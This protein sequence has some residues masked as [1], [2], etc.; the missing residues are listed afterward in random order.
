M[1]QDKNKRYIG[2]IVC[3]NGHYYFKS[4]K[5]SVF[6]IIQDS[7]AKALCENES[8]CVFELLKTKNP[9]DKFGKV[10]KILDN[11]RN[12][13][14]IIQAVISAYDL[15]KTPSKTILS[16]ISAVPE[17]VSN[18]DMNDVVDL[19]GVPFVTIDPDNAGDYDDAVYACKNTDG[20]YTLKVAISNV[21]HYIH[22]NTA[23]F[24]NAIEIGNTTYLADSGFVFPMFDKKISNGICS[25]KEGEDRL[26][27]CT[28]MTLDQN[29]KLINYYI[30]PAVVN[31]RHRLTYKEADFLYF[32]KN[33]E[34]DSKDHSKIIEKTQNVKASLNDLYEVS[35]IL[36]NA[37][38]K[39][40]SFDINS[41]EIVFKIDE[42]VA[43]VLGYLKEHDEKFTSVIEETAI[44]HNEIWGEIAFRSG[45]PFG[46]RNHKQIE[47][48][49]IFELR[50][51]LAQFNINIP[52]NISNR[53]LQRIINDVKGKRI[54]DYVVSCI[55]KSMEPAYYESNNIGH[56]GLG[57]VRNEFSSLAKEDRGVGTDLSLF[58]NA[59]K[60]YFKR[61][62]KAF[63]LYFDGDINHCAY[64]Q[65]TSP[66]RRGEDLINQI[67]MQNMIKKGNV[68]F[69]KDQ[70]DDYLSHLNYTEIRSQN[71]ESD[72]NNM[73]A[74]MWASNN[75]GLIFE[76]CTM[77][78]FGE[79]EAKILTKDGLVMWLPYSCIGMP[80]SHLK[81]G[82]KLSNLQIQKVSFNPPKIICARVMTKDFD[83]DLEK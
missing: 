54:E 23:L 41:G 61:T 16:E 6:D 14:S 13:K 15:E 69:R 37:R 65:S 50:H 39:R 26:V 42:H 56:A 34:G 59:R 64:S 55:L 82:K 4:V 40:G 3:N 70:I 80:R 49:K 45:L 44:I 27:M 11:T 28:T 74:T 62:G 18:K 57:I 81:I 68:T 17:K 75:I 78:D 53:L 10:V 52:K 9:N 72:L 67:Q 12:L 38:M 47:K 35:K 43:N 83:K 33:H 24:N 30:E 29:G 2:N 63:G 8:L 32:G 20:T 58:D 51:K 48:D 25:I 5:G 31:S 71:A 76:D 22:P 21:A 1:G 73:L 60:E 19:R 66:I 79:N 77:I 46:Y 36:Y 7:D